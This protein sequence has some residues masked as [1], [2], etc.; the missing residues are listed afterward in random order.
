MGKAVKPP[1]NRPGPYNWANWARTA[2]RGIQTGVKLYNAYTQTQNNKKVKSGQGVTLQK[3]RA[4]IYRRR[5]APARKRRRARRAMRSF[6]SKILKMKG[7]RTFVSNNQLALSAAAGKQLVTSFVLFGGRVD[8]AVSTAVDRG[9]DDMNDMRSKD[10]L[11]GDPTGDA[12]QRWAPGD[13]K[14][15]VKTG[16]MDITLQNNDTN[17]YAHEI[18]IY[19]F[20][21]GQ[22]PSIAGADVESAIQFYNQD[23]YKQ[24]PSASLTALTQDMRGVTPFE[25]GNSMAKIRMKIL[26]KTKYFIPFGDTITY[27]IRDTK[28]RTLNH[29]V[30]RDV[31]CTTRHTR[32]IYIVAKPTVAYYTGA[33][34]LIVGVTRKYKYVVDESNTDRAALFDVKS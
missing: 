32:G 33:I 28:I 1:R 26:K 3:D 12:Q 16:I 9:Y 17:A 4:L 10:V 29:S 27:Q 31:S 25:F 23:T 21:C 14:W 11:L 13:T 5:R 19:E 7:H 22:I 18:D 8:G 30:F 34:N 6:K 15:Y 20:T 2:T 24:G